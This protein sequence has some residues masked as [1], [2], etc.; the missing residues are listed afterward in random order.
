MRWSERLKA[1]MQMRHWKGFWPV[2]M[3]MW[4]VSSSERLKRRSQLS[5]GHLKLEPLR[6]VDLILHALGGG[7]AG[8]L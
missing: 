3:R 4:R 6:L 2:W 7:G 8:Y 1:R 5:R